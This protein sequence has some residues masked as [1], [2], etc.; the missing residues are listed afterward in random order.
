MSGAEVVGF[1][2]ALL[3][4]LISAAEHY[5]DC[6]RPILRY[7]KIVEEVHLFQRN[8][9]VQRTIFRNQCRILLESVI[10]HDAAIRMLGVG[11]NDPSWGDVDLEEQLTE[12]LGASKEACAT[13][14]ELINERLQS[15]GKESRD[16]Q[17]VA[18]P[19][20]AVK[21][22][23]AKKIRF[24]ISES[25]LDEYITSLRAL[26]DDFT[27][28]SNQTKQGAAYQT[29]LPK[30]Q[31]R[32]YHKEISKYKAVGEAS[33]KVYKALGKACTKHSEHL[34]HFCINPVSDLPETISTAQIHF[35]VAFT[36]LPLAGAD[37]IPASDHDEPM[38]FMID[39]VTS[40]S[41]VTRP[42][43][44]CDRG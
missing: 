19:K 4:L 22:R 5:D 7:R 28:L 12:Q 3:P 30:T 13:S 43:E 6:I 14:I 41:T 2:L 40:D 1:T 34:A 44:D 29:R 10:E 36:R 18:D 32:P 9:K 20:Q 11:S 26:N 15:I 23:L 37:G 31:S 27:K 39:T 38:W 17:A 33:E 24:S 8:L 35:R 42:V 25:R 21:H 16:L